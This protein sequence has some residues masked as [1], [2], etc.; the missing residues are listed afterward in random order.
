MS[1]DVLIADFFLKYVDV[2]SDAFSGEGRLPYGLIQDIA[3]I[4]IAAGVFANKREM[5]IK[6]L[7]LYSIILPEWIFSQS[8]P[9]N[10]LQC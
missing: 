10:Q 3:F 4:L 9:P 8:L 5:R 6:A 1:F 7:R 2:S